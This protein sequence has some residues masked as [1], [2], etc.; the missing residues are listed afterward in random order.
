M[1]DKIALLLSLSKSG[2]TTFEPKL[3]GLD[4]YAMVD[5]VRSMA[6]N[7]GLVSRTGLLTQLG[8]KTLSA[9]GHDSNRIIRATRFSV[10]TPNCSYFINMTNPYWYTHVPIKSIILHIKLYS[11]TICF[12]T[13]K[14]IARVS[15]NDTHIKL[16][17]SNGR[18]LEEV[19]Q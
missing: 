10:F 5:A 19:R 3:I 15:S 11:H 1:K 9:L 2:F 4:N 13:N 6:Y 7:M 8:K 12:F 18:L 14:G 16:Q 17:T